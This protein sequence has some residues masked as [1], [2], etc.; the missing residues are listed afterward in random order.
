MEHRDIAEDPQRSAPEPAGADAGAASR[1]ARAAES[2][3]HAPDIPRL[4]WVFAA[5]GFALVAATIG[6]IAWQGYTG[7]GSPPQL[8]FEVRAIANVPNGYLV[9]VLAVNNGEETA[10][11]VKVEGE[12]RGASGT[13]ETSETSFKYLPPRSWR[14]GG[15]YFA[16]DPRTLELSIRAK[17][18][19]AP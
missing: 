3:Q 6:F 18:Y 5:I 13:V 14:S 7:N 11:D 4:E 8:S 17:G 16:N 1:L 9:E 2:A 15:L 10:A 19:E 12:L